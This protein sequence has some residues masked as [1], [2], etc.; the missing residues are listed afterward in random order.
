VQQRCRCRT[1]ARKETGWNG[2]R[3]A[4][5]S[6]AEREETGRA[7]EKNKARGWVQVGVG[8]RRGRGEGGQW[9][10]GDGGEPVE[11]EM[12]VERAD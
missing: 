9:G 2:E 1:S 10:W 7:R 8:W 11:S 3:G 5:H 6:A 4:Q 12:T